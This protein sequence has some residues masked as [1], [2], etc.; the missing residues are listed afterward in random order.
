MRNTLRY[1]FEN[2][3]RHMRDVGKPLPP[4]FIDAFSSAATSNA[5]LLH[6][7]CWLVRDA[8]RATG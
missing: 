7:G 4:G 8:E 2:H 5:N 6:P 3:A 1:V